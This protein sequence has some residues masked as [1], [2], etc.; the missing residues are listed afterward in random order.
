[1]RHAHLTSLTL[2]IASMAGGNAYNVVHAADEPLSV[3]QR[4]Q[5][6][7]RE[8]KLLKEAAAQSSGASAQP[9]DPLPKFTTNAKDGFS[10]SSPDGAYRLR[11]GG[12]AQMEGRFFLEDKELPFNNTF[13]FSK[14]R[15]YFEGTIATHF[16]YRVI[17][18]L[19]TSP[20]MIEA[21]VT[22][23]IDPR[24]KITAGRF[25]VLFGLETLQ[26]DAATNLITRGLP[27]A[28]T[29]SRDVGV[30]ASG[31]VLNG[32]LSYAIGVFNGPVDGASNTTDNGDDKDGFARLFATPFKSSDQVGLQGL[33]FGIAVSYGHQ[34]GT[35]GAATNSLPAYRTPG[36]N[37]F[38]TYD[39]TSF[40]AGSR[41]RYTPQLYW[42]IAA[43]DV[44]GEYVSTTQK[45]REATSEDDITN[46]AWQVSVGY[47]IT[48][49]K[50]S[51]KGVNPAKAVGSDSWGAWQIVARYGVLDIDDQ[52]FS[53]NFA[54][55]T[56]QASS[57]TNIGVGV[58]WIL[59][60]NIKLMLNY[61]QI[62]F[63]DG[64]ANGSAAKD[65]ETEHVI[66]SRI[67]FTF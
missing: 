5:A 43:F 32:A 2:L 14:V 50:A 65:R 61:D 58:N 54:S 46:T 40:S 4:L 53:S 59:N 10:L 63:E 15:P 3:E 60:R 64:A 52:A 34:D 28:L 12:L 18:D 21:H 25:K 41:I 16:D 33:G 22:A 23:N 62:E 45:I 27:S 29:P 57:A 7:D 37:A 11:I 56:T 36:G 66:Q 67:Q 17:L 20:A 35:S 31:D 44:L 51:F 55:R 6:L 39:A 1:M 42:S 19:V 8:V 38:F 13:S 30:Q 26:S 49:E 48:G 9:K 24:F 47:V